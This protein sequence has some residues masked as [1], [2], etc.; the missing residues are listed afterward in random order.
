MSG[1]NTSKAVKIVNNKLIAT[2]NIYQLK[3]LLKMSF[4]NK[5]KVSKLP[6]EIK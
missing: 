3:H 5:L 4:V 2:L 1:V 6:I